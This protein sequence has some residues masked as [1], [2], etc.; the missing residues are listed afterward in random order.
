MNSVRGIQLK[1]PSHQRKVE[2]EV[3]DNLKGLDIS[4]SS[5]HSEDGARRTNIRFGSNTVINKKEDDGSVHMDESDIE[6]GIKSTGH[7]PSQ[8]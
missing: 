1:S 3:F 7:R 6:G 2:E 4:Y 8:K 5:E